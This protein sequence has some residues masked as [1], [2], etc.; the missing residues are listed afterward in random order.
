MK[1][2]N[3]VKGLPLFAQLMINDPRLKGVKIQQAQGI[4]AS[5]DG[6]VIHL[7]T[8]FL[9]PKADM[10]E[11]DEAEW[12]DYAYTT[13][14][15][16]T[17]EVGHVLHTDWK[18]LKGIDPDSHRK[19]LLNLLEDPRIDAKMVAE[20]PGTTVMY[21]VL[22]ERLVREGLESPVTADAAPN[23][24]LF[25]WM[26][27]HARGTLL[28]E[29][30]YQALRDQARPVVEQHFGADLVTHLADLIE[31]TRYARNTKQV[32]TLTD[33]IL[34]FLEEAAKPPEPPEG[35]PQSSPEDQGSQEQ[36]G[37]AQGADGG[38]KGDQDGKTSP[39]ASD[40]QGKQDASGN[41]SPSSADGQGDKTPSPKPS[42]GAKNDAGLDPD[43]AQKLADALKAPSKD[44][45]EART[46]ALRKEQQDD[47]EQQ[48]QKGATA[49]PIDPGAAGSGAGG[50]SGTQGLS[51]SSDAIDTQRIGAITATARM[52]LR[53]LLNGRALD[54]VE[55]RD[56]GSKLSMKHAYRIAIG[57]PRIW[58]HRIEGEGTDTA[59]FLLIDVSG[60][61]GGQIVTAREAA[62]ATALTFRGMTGVT[63]AVGTFPGNGM[64]MPFGG[65]PMSHGS[66]FSFNAWGGTPMAEGIQFAGQ[67]LIARPERRKLLIVV[68]DGA[69]DD[70]IRASAALRMMKHAGIETVGIGIGT[71]SVRHLF[72]VSEVMQSIE[73]LPNVL[74]VTL[75]TQLLES[76]KAA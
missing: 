56:R 44:F 36:A 64:V 10:N 46:A 61:M 20:R 18:A 27:Y 21:D 52:R 43:Q 26:H 11:A 76:R 24:A 23:D 66:R 22:G 15:L 2:V 4:E 60:S 63:T 55:V 72:P 58:Q 53:N 42:A 75:K 67:H 35:D 12:R 62:Y 6:K 68:T 1:A 57:D 48:Q 47:T 16:T 40:D 54:D 41:A 19:H 9:T 74:F 38:Q 28:N 51:L 14:G 33:R 5:T 32:L 50:D 8:Y 39:S 7:P 3:L 25:G 49:M 73:A 29:A 34:A 30:A 45:A 17:H 13:M 65:S 37:G 71:Q 59:I 69:P 70:A 31:E